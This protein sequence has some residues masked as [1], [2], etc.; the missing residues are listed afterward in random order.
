MTILQKKE[1]SI[2]DFKQQ[3]IIAFKKFLHVF[4]T[5]EKIKTSSV[6][7]SAAS[8]GRFKLLDTHFIQELS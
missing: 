7:F 1:T 8:G 4:M 2:L 6:P 5:V 3:F